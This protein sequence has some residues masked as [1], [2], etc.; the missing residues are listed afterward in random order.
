MKSDSI[1]SF[2]IL[3][4][5]F[6]LALCGC[7]NTEAINKKNEKSEQESNASLTL[8]DGL[9]KHEQLEFICS[10]PELYSPALIALAENHLDALPFVYW[11]PESTF[12]EREPA[13]ETE[14]L[15]ET[16]LLLQWDKL[17]GSGSYAG[18][19]FGLTGCGPTCLSMAAIYLTGKGEYTPLFCGN[20]AEEHGYTVP[21]DGTA[22]TLFSDGVTGLGMTSAELPLDEAVMQRFAGWGAPIILVLGPGDFTA[23]GHYVVI[24]GWENGGF[25]INDPNSKTN[26]SRS[27][28]Y[29]ELKDQIRCIWVLWGARME[30]ISLRAAESGVNIRR[31]AGLNSDIIGTAAERETLKITALKRS[32]GLIWG[33]IENRGWICMSYVEKKPD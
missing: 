3:I 5:F 15:S 22:W 25:L 9:G 21:G 29:D 4:L 24:R 30:N 32:D 1:L 26:S 27:W 19:W 2:F 12:L 13:I 20:Y 7:K 14:G 33:H 16:P 23:D 10:H 18:S 17:R 8:Q 31:E 28:T 6:L 11:T